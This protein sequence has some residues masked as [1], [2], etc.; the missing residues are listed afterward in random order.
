MKRMG[1]LFAALLFAATGV[2]AQN[3]GGR[4]AQPPAPATKQEWT[5]ALSAKVKRFLL[6]PP[7]IDGV[8]GPH[9][10]MVSFVVH[11][12]GTVTDIEIKQSSGVAQVDESARRAIARIA[13]VAPFP[14]EMTGESERITAPI[15]MDLVLPSP[16]TKDL[17]T[18]FTFTT[19]AEL[20]TI[21]KAD[22]SNEETLIYNLASAAPDRIPAV[23][24]KPVCEIG[25]RQWAKDH[26][27]YGWS[28]EK[29]NSDTM[30]DELGKSVREEQ[31]KDGNTIEESR[32]IDMK[33]AKA[34]EMILAPASGPESEKFRRYAVF[35]DTPTGRISL[36]CVTTP[37]AFATAS[38]V[39]TA[40][41]QT[42]QVER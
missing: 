7:P 27:R 40:L 11:R 29:L 39:F 6:L 37:E 25:F 24:D 13:P 1:L 21:G 9:T 23:A 17:A 14:P 2:M 22:A 4:V 3:K 20:K 28:Q 41:A 5:A 36:S 12:D 19:P 26:P 10:A 30:F 35:A 32:T 31:E 16:T 8:S 34:V 18:G 42:A 33:G 38:P 15:R